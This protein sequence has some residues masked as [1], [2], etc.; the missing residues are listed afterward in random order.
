MNA[1]F[2]VMAIVLAA[3]LAATSARAADGRELVAMPPM[4]QE[5]M[6][7]SMRD[8]LVVLNEILADL[9]EEKYAE[10]AKVAEARLGMSSFGLH[11]ASHMAPHM[12]KGM[13]EAGESLHRAASRFAL[14]AQEAD[15]ERSY[16]AMRKLTGALGEM[17]TACAACHAGYR[18]R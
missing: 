18:I 17:T 16:A 10:A 5:H 11:G 12:P 1:R 4:M 3:T 14:L 15:V 13:R 6:L 9:A 2:P 8:H 7:A